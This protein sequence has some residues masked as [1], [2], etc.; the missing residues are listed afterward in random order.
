MG[1]GSGGGG[2]STQVQKSDPWAGQQ[3]YLQDIFAQ[4]QGQYNSNMP[5]Y[6]PNA[7][8][9]PVTADTT[10]AQNAARTAATGSAS[11]LAAKGAAAESY[12]LGQVLDP[13]SNPFFQSAVAGAIR[14][15]VT[16][17]TN[18]GGPL[19]AIRGGAVGADQ[20]GG[21]RQGIAEGAA[22]T[23]LGQ[24]MQ[25]IVANMGSQAYGQGLT[26][27]GTALAFLPQTQQAQ[28]FPATALSAVGQDVQQQQQQIIND[29]VAKWNWEQ[30]L[31]A[32]KLQQY[33]NMVTGATGGGST[34]STGTQPTARSNPLMG[35]LG[36]AAL[37]FSVGGP[38]GAAAGGLIGLLAS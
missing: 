31:P 38:W 24:S 28:M 22:I 11:D 10:A 18:P 4:A 25:D 7:T 3:P 30:G 2:T 29:A 23:G 9:A 35:A 37:G 34:T 16:Q 32:A 14:P 20:Y 15:M 27:Q 1:G 6:Y 36:G 19:S 12:R 26:A 17:F 13:N 8:L 5:Q 33:A 21:S